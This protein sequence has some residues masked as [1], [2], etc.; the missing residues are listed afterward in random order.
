MKNNPDNYRIKR[1]IRYGYVCV[2]NMWLLFLN[3]YSNKYGRTAC[4]VA[5]AQM[6]RERAYIPVA[7]QRHLLGDGVE[8]WRLIHDPTHYKCG[9]IY[10]MALQ[11]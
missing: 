5:C 8:T 3:I 1:K 10:I 7:D 9:H 6:D 11:A 4:K 2:N